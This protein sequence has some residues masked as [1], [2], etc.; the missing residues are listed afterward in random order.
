M[1]N[2]N[3]NS[4]K[5]LEDAESNQVF[6]KVDKPIPNVS[7]FSEYVTPE[8]VT[9][10]LSY[11]APKPTVERRELTIEERLAQGPK[12]KDKSKLETILFGPDI[13]LQGDF[14]IPAQRVVERLYRKATDKE[15]EPV[16]NFST[17][18]SMVA[19][20]IDGNIKLVKFPINIA[21]EVIDLARGSGID[22][23]KSAVAKVEKYFTDS[24][25][26][27]VGTEAEEIAFSDAAGK[28]TSAAVQI[29]GLSKPTQL[30]TDWGFKTANRYFQAA[31]AGK[32][33][34]ASKNLEQATKEAI[35][36]NRLSG[37]QKFASFMIGGGLGMAAVSDPEDFGTLS[38][39][40]EGTRFESTLG[41]L[42][43]D[44]E[45]KTNPQDEAARRLW[46]RAKLGI[47]TGLIT[48]PILWTGGLVGKIIKKQ[49]KD[50]YASNDDLDRWVEKYFIS[51]LRARGVKSEELFEEVQR[52]KN[53]VSSGQ[54][55]SID[56]IK[57]IDASL[58]KI[59]KE[60]NINKG[61]PELKRLIGR[62]DELLVTGNDIIKGKEFLFKGFDPKKLSEFRKFASTE[63]GLVDD[64][65]ER[66]VAELAKA[67]N[68]FNTY[69]NTFFAGGNINVAANDFAKIMS[70]R[71]QNIW[72][73]EYRIFED[74]FK[75]FPWLRY[76]PIQSNLD[77][78]KQVLGR[79]AAQNGKKLTDQELDDQLQTM[80]KE[81]KRDPLTGAPEFP[82]YDQSILANDGIK[83]QY[84]N[85][86][87][88]FEGGRFKPSDLF[89]TE[90]DI[91]TFQ[92]LFG[93]KRD[94]RN[95][96]A[97]T[98][99]DLATLTSK[100]T[101][102]NNILKL[103]DDLIKQ[104]RPGVF[105]DSPT[106]AR[107][108]LRNVIG[109]E[110]IITTKG[111][112]NIKSPIGEDF[113]TNPL[114]GKYTSKPYADALNFSEKVLF[115]EIARNT[116][117]QHLVLIPKGLTQVSKTVLGPFTHT[118]NFITQGQFVLANGNLFKDPRKI[119]ENFKRA[120]NTIQPQLI[121]KNL[122]KD[123]AMARFLIEEGVMSSSAIAAD[124]SGL[125]DDM[126]KTGD[127]YSRLF[128][129]FGNKMKDLYKVA[130]DLYVA[131]DDIWKVYSTFSEF[132]NYKN[133]YTNAV[134]SGKLKNMPTDLEIMKQATK[135]VRDTLPNYAYVG[136]FIK[137]MRRTPLG[138][139]MSWPASVIRS[140]LKTFE[141]AQ[142]EIK[143]PILHSQGVKRMMTFGT[144]T[145]AS[146]PAIQSM[147]HGVYGVTNKMVAAARFFVPDFSRNSTIILTQDADGNFK[148]IDGS[149]SFVYD[150]LTSPFQSTIA[151]INISTAY[152]PKAPIIPAAYKGLI[153]GIGKLM[154]PFISE[155][156]W[157][158]TFNNLVVRNGVTPDG[159]RLWNP[160]M[161]APDKV[162]EALKYFIEQTAPGS[163]KQSVRLK[164]S[165]T[166]EPGA[167]GEKYEI[168]DEVAGFYGLRQIKLEPIK[169][170]DF[171]LNE[172][173]KAVADARKIFTVPAQRGGEI[174]GDEFIENFY[175]ANRKKY[176]AMNNLKITNEMAEILNV[177]KNQ[178]ARTYDDRNLLKDYKYL[179]S[180]NFRPYT[181]S[182]PL[183]QKTEEIYKDLST[184]FDNIEITKT[185]NNQTLNS[186]SRMIRD[187]SRV[188]L[189]E[190]LNNYINI[191]DY[192]IGDKP[193]LLGPRS[194]GPT[195]VQPLPPQPQP[196]P[197]VVSKP[198]MPM[199]QQTGL[200][201]TETGLLTD[202]E[203][204]IRL[205]QQGLA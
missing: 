116:W 60:A 189:G 98:M 167:R 176:E 15:V 29:F 72:T 84:L 68:T 130:F 147:V 86:A 36:L 156:I 202:A 93:Q 47:E 58:L 8:E 13:E 187:M 131:E 126:S 149:G 83:V 114:N 40:L 100:D 127:V 182:K 49:A 142:K 23:D 104:K 199:N 77:D 34:T 78:A 201:A 193:S 103:N 185:L 105:Y 20:L 85:M 51:P 121:Y 204:A 79:Y 170:M 137:S 9:D 165:I 192:L 197:Q 115:D 70:E 143:D 30:L 82:L 194:E 26:G 22:P 135:I 25:L 125:I 32:V 35:K 160:Q 91:R 4:I 139:F 46:N 150:T 111:G 175:Y 174:S 132:D 17:T 190:N 136:D 198:P 133:L 80:L 200:T 108:G 195:N 117:Y 64:Q 11:K 55:A 19:A 52:V 177:T 124:I 67:R 69:K 37:K 129:K 43:L 81:V 71:M 153:R 166:G 140:G 188:P 171:K 196:D 102:Y 28:L 54:I 73:S 45:R 161:D 179:E 89:K 66:L 75:I 155:S 141:L 96:I 172:Y 122:P 138:N 162:I 119:A 57:D 173:Q 168:N 112:L 148:Y 62:M 38:D 203:K 65:I 41:I 48:W 120:F 151:E 159:R 90:K 152:D 33:A 110:D 44:E 109:G 123:Q 14:G 1:S 12:Y 178:L 107:S 50:V 184:N 158:E 3:F 146:L 163:Y 10:G 181:I 39:L 95:T 92:R 16:D 144:V 76:K 2:E 7:D 169:K 74:N 6:S 154:E 164:K 87:K 24:I 128:G 186:L 94:L 99:S 61:T 180:N 183:V 191:E 27:K 106:A 53:K 56:I 18:E 59:A 134:K 97:S 31:K 42:G 21:S 5:E 113:Y 157:L 205:R 118:R 63:L 101:F 88:S 145:A